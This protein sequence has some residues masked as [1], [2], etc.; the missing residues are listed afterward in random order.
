MAWHIIIDWV[1]ALF[2]HSC[3]STPHSCIFTWAGRRA[4]NHG[5]RNIDFWR[6]VDTVIVIITIATI[7]I[8]IFI[9]FVIVI[10]ITVIISIISIITDIIAVVALIIAMLTVTVVLIIMIV[11]VVVHSC[12]QAQKG[13]SKI[14]IRSRIISRGVR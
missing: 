12:R 4:G 2:S 13:L 7:V 1:H 3:V 9:F 10:I 14:I 6:L 5:I 11:I 8:V